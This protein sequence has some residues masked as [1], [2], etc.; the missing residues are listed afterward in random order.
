MGSPHRQIV[1]AY[2]GAR[3]ESYDDGHRLHDL[4][5][6]NVSAIK[7]SMLDGWLMNH[8]SSTIYRQIMILMMKTSVPCFNTA[9]DPL[10]VP[11]MSLTPAPQ[12]HPFDLHPHTRCLNLMW[13]ITS[14]QL[15][16]IMA[17]KRT[18]CKILQPLMACQGEPRHPTSEV[19]PDQLKHGDNDRLLELT[20]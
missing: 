1:M 12:P 7:T 9:K 19:R 18:I 8:Y 2:Q 3:G 11:L 13:A 17:I 16:H 6:G 15:L 10:L 4:P 14:L 20:P 5:P